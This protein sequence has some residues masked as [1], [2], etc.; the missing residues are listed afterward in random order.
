MQSSNLGRAN[1]THLLTTTQP[2][3]VTETITAEGQLST[4]V[5]NSLLTQLNEMK[6]Q[7]QQMKQF[8]K[9]HLPSLKKRSTGSTPDQTAKSGTQGNR[10]TPQQQSS[11][12]TSKVNKVGVG[13]E[14]IQEDVLPSFLDYL[15]YSR[16]ILKRRHEFTEPPTPHETD[17]AANINVVLFSNATMASEFLIGIGKQKNTGLFDSRTSHSCIS[18]QCYKESIPHVAISEAAHISVENASGESMD[19]LGMC[20]A[21]IS[22]GNKRFTHVFIVCKNLTSSLILGLDFSSHF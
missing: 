10:K 15:I 8:V 21:T 19:P 17:Y 14:D 13:L 22:L 3:R 11:N 1:Q 4:T 6:S 5:W 18:Y 7:N 2:P 16:K 9:K 12:H 20:E